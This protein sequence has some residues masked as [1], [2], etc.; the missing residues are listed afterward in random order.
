MRADRLTRI[1]TAAV[2]LAVAAI[3]AIISY[4]H[5]YTLAASHGESGLTAR[6]VPL[7]VDGLIFAA[8]M[9]ILDASRSA[10]RVPPLAGWKLD[11]PF[12]QMTEE[13]EAEYF[14]ANRQEF[15]RNAK[16]PVSLERVVSTR[17]SE[18]ELALIDEAASAVGIKLSTFIRRA[19]VEAAGLPQAAPDATGLAKLHAEL[20][21]ALASV[22][23][24]EKDANRRAR[25]KSKGT[26]VSAE[27][28][29][30]GG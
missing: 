16:T 1:T 26:Q 6:L 13:E 23:D 8:S 9:V 14:Y 19:A 17:F 27:R 28:T 10:R 11:K 4:Q 21:A 29:Q 30:P 22:K 2:V 15:E 3:A 25:A 5:A 24:M 20:S 18:D 12:E 7:T